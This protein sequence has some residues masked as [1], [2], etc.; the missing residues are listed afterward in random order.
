MYKDLAL[1]ALLFA[2]I[3]HPK[4]RDRNNYSVPV[5]LLS[6]LLYYYFAII[7]QLITCVLL[8]PLIPQHRDRNNCIPCLYFCFQSYCTITSRLFLSYLLVYFTTRLSLNTGTG[9]TVFHACISA[10]KL[11]YYYLAIISQ[12]ILV[13]F[14]LRSNLKTGTG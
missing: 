10:R 2:R 9:I 7:S 11:L 8:P 13:Y 1:S 5:F 12:L 3:L 4:H 14:S 6:K